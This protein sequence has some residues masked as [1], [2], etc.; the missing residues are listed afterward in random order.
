MDRNFWHERWQRNEIGFHQ[1]STH[2]ELVKH[3]STVCGDSSATV[4]VPLCG[5]SLDIH[6][7]AE[8]GHSVIGVE[9]DPG[10][11]QAFF[12]EAGMTPTADDSG[13][14]PSWSSGHITLFA[15]DFFEFTHPHG[16][17][18]VYD[19]AALIALPPDMRPRYLDHLASL[20]KPGAQGLLVTLEYPQ[21]RMQGPPFSVMPE[22]L[23]A[24]AGFEFKCLER[25]DVLDSHQRFAEKGIPWLRESVYAF[26]TAV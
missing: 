6:W 18:L 11:V 7:L 21:E 26:R 20:M 16:F 24:F 4:L 2:P 8:Q 22:E 10:A 12:D 14:M 5:K 25:S 3:W 9:L 1:E 15:G 13:V 19:R 23:H 17:D